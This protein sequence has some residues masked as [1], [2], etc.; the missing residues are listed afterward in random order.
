MTVYWTDE[1]LEQVS[2]ISDLLAVTSP[3]YAERVVTNLFDRVR[4][5]ADHPKL[6]PVYRKAGLPQVR[7]LLVKPYRVVYYVGRKQL[8]II[9]VLHQRQ[10]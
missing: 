8:E 10:R 9:A 7:E 3:L 4:T 5:L 6:G 1:A 2:A